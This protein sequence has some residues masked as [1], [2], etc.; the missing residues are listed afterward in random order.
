MRRRL[1]ILGCMIAAAAILSVPI[2]ALSADDAPRIE[3]EQLKERLH[4]PGLHLL[5][6]RT[7]SDWKKSDRKI[8]GAVRVDPHDV[9]AWA[10]TLPKDSFIV[11]Y[12]S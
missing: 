3:P 12:C 7:A 6:V 4:Q 10:K 2:A 8:V 1:L 5:D 9:S 11:A